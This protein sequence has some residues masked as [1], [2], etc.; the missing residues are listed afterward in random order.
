MDT[1]SNA[2]SSKKDIK[3]AGEQ[4]ILK[5]HG[6]SSSKSLNEYRFFAYTQTNNHHH[7]LLLLQSFIRC[8]PVDW[9][10]SQCFVTSHERQSGEV[11]RVL[12]FSLQAFLPQVLQQTNI[13]TNHTVH[14]WM[15]NILPPSDW[16]KRFKMACW[17]QLKLIFRL[18]LRVFSIL[19]HVDARL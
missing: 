12:P 6:G 4:F 16:G 13:H 7:L 9:S 5:L 19:F 1:F 3:D 17:Y 11:L 10:C 8:E 18:L 15:G 2:G 14:Q